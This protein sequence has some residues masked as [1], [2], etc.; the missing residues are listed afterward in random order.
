MSSAAPAQPDF[1]ARLS[2]A[3]G[4]FFG[5]LLRLVFVLLLAVTLGAGVYF[6][7][8]WAYRALIQPV[9]THTAQIQELFNRVE[10]LR[11]ST[12]ESQ[13]AQNERLTALETG[14]DA[15]RL[16][17]DAAESE[18]TALSGA[19]AE[20]SAARAALAEQ[21]AALQTQLDEQAAAAGE[22]SAAVAGLEP[23]A[24]DT[25]E[26]VA[27]LQRQLT[28]VRLQSDLLR[29]RVQVVAENFGEARAV[30]TVTVSAMQRFLEA[31]GVFP[32]SAQS[33]LAVRLVSAAA[34]I[35]A[36]PAAALPDLESIWAEMDRI[37]SS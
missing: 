17:L 14:Y 35:E 1:W 12:E 24:A 36:E 8:P 31:P 34:L 19:L 5:F 20:E 29:A 32:A 37:L 33:A 3:L 6:G 21:V 16:R 11:S 22:V 9:E 15:E 18:I 4:R 27:A 30:L 28:L 23:A 2:R 10:G 26:Q 7:V 13:N 25:A